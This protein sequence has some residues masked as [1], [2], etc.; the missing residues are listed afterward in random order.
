MEAWEYIARKEK[1][2]DRAG[3][4]RKDIIGDFTKYNRLFYMN[5]S[6]YEDAALLFFSNEEQEFWKMDLRTGIFQK[7]NINAGRKY[8]E[9]E[10]YDNKLFCVN[11]DDLVIEVFS[12][13]KKRRF[14]NKRVFRIV[15]KE[16]SLRKKYQF[17]IW[18]NR[19]ERGVYWCL[20]GPISDGRYINFEL[21]EKW[22]TN[23][24]SEWQIKQMFFLGI[25]LAHEQEKYSDIVCAL[26]KIDNSIICFDR[27]TGH[28]F[29]YNGFSNKESKILKI[30]NLEKLGCKRIERMY[31]YFPYI[32]IQDR[33]KRNEIK[34][35]HRGKDEEYITNRYRKLFICVDKKELFEMSILT[36]NKVGDKQSEVWFV[37]AENRMIEN[38]SG[39]IDIAFD[40]REG[41]LFILYEKRIKC[42]E[43]SEKDIVTPERI[44][45]QSDEQKIGKSLPDDME[46]S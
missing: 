5:E 24:D 28:F 30:T 43:V 41:G 40:T 10:W 19:E 32:F 21:R 13:S 38:M 16:I 42:R 22:F 7:E 44:R 46:S 1:F 14:Y 26:N 31:Y 45:I 25:D 2:E 12:S 11:G 29:E 23:E 17:L 37:D 36:S 39:I 4:K 33:K 27:D 9:V 3:E 20:L 34:S 18:K 15:N 6:R 8:Q 35:I